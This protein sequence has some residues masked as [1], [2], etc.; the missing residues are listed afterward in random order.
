MQDFLVNDLLPQVLPTIGVVLTGIL[1]TIIK[2]IGNEAVEYISKKKE[3][4]EQQLNSDKNREILEVGKQIWNIVEEN[5]RITENLGNF[6]GSKA[7]MFDS[8]LV[9]KFPVLTE[10]QI[11]EIRQTIAGE[12]NRGKEALFTDSFKEEAKKIQEDNSKLI[13]ENND[14]KNKLNIIS[15]NILTNSENQITT[16]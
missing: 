10:K 12:I 13:Q 15:Q 1:V 7:E 9:E 4:V 16:M 5:F 6:I 3:V 2:K 11:E 8:L 14:L